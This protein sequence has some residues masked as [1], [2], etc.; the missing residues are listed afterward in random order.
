MSRQE[1]LFYERNFRTLYF[2]LASDRVY[3]ATRVATGAVGFYPAFSPVPRTRRGGL[4]SATLS[5]GLPRPDVI[6]YRVPGKPGLSSTPQRGQRLSDRLT[7]LFYTKT[8]E[9]SIPFARFISVSDLFP[10][11]KAVPA[12]MILELFKVRHF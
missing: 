4:F 9:K 8:D 11:G 7:F 10:I 6:R 1:H 5:V 2:S 3:P 12:Y